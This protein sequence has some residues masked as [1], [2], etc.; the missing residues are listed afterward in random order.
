M[1]NWTTEKNGLAA[2]MK[3]ETAAGRTNCTRVHKCGYD[4]ISKGNGQERHIEVKTTGKG[5]FTRRWLEEMEY[6]ALQKDKNFWVYLVTDANGKP[7]VREL[8]AAQV[9]AKFV[10]TVKHYWFDF[11]YTSNSIRTSKGDNNER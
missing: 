8:S 5:K 3:H 6:Q 2:V 1:S 11:S 4:I 10:K 7:S 9:K